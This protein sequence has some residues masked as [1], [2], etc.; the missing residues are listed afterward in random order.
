MDNNFWKWLIIDTLG[1]ERVEDV[2]KNEFD[3]E[4]LDVFLEIYQ[5]R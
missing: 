2:D 3:D 1:H 4:S 5:T